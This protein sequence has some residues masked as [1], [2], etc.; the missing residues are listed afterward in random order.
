MT[1][2]P[3]LPPPAP[4]R[5]RSVLSVP[6]SD[7]R[8]TAK[9]L[10]G[11]ADQVVLDLEDA[12]EPGSKD[13]A[14]GLLVA[15]LRELPDSAVDRV[16]VRVNPARSPWCA[17][18]VAALAELPVLPGSLVLPKVEGPGDLAFLDR[19]LDGAEARSGRRRRTGVQ[20]LVETAAGFAA[21]PETVRAGER[22]EALVLGYADLAAS[23]GLVAAPERRL[24][25]WLPVQTAVLVAARSR[26]VMAV[27]GPYLGVHVDQGFTAS[28]E[29]ARDLGFDG[30]W[31]IHPRQVEAL[32][33]VFTPSPEQVEHARA[34]LDTLERAAREGAAGAVQLEGEMLDEAVAVAAR[35]VLARTEASTEA[36]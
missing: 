31:A 34:V 4:T 33:A 29:R 22:L 19:L 28:A 13:R 17:L 35:R 23:L 36:S 6:A 14:R 1:A 15:A 12:V 21:L 3:S 32:N 20:A 30:K 8:K 27:D 25:L 10:A 18:D 7:P 16:T 11:P 9:A 24:A 26:G 2:V 5:R